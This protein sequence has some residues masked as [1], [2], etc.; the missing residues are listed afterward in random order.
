MRMK[1]YL[2]ALS[3]L[4]I[5]I[6]L[7]PWQAVAAG[8][9][10]SGYVP[11]VPDGFATQ[12]DPNVDIYYSSGG[13]RDVAE[14]ATDSS[15]AYATVSR[16]FGESPDRVKVI[17]GSS[18]QE[19]ENIMGVGKLPDYSMGAGWGDG[20]IGTIVIK[21]PELVPNFQTV[22]THELTH[23]ATRDY[24]FGYKYAL[25]DWLSEGLAVYVSSDLPQDKRR[26][27]N[28]QCREGKLMSIDSLNNVLRSS[29][30][31]DASINQVGSAYTQS[32]L[33]VEY[34]GSKYGNQTLL[35]ILDAFGP[36][37]DL[38]SAFMMVIGKTPQQVDDEWQ[39]GLKGELDRVDGKILEQTVDG[40]IINQHGAPMPN[41]TVSFTALRN[42]SIVQGTV[43]K[44]MTNDSGYYALNVT[45]GPLSV[46]SDKAEYEGFN[47]T[48]T[49]GRKDTKFLNVTLNG[50]ALELRLAAEA[51]AEQD[52][53][54]TMYVI[55]AAFNV[56]AIAAG[57]IVVMRMRK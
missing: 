40:Y 2:K 23:I 20:D 39:S 5:L 55:L 27:I 54:N 24:I 25:P 44:A 19:Y 15:L 43:Y 42:D 38:N 29:T 46:I 47:Q 13:A 31:A 1:C 32:G 8:E 35:R 10:V 28:D 49:L 56:I 30:A 7:L 11:V 51:K 36:S 4:I 45:Y 50:T 52:R 16:F 41:E 9:T 18:Q 33:L 17:I 53:R 57:A 6:M 34:I 26:M 48:I 3:A 14:V 21:S 12:W 37:G 22:L